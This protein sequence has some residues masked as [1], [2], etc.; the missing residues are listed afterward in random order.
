M[1]PGEVRDIWIPKGTKSDTEGTFQQR[2]AIPPFESIP[3]VI[4]QRAPH[5]A[6]KACQVRGKWCRLERGIHSG[7]CYWVGESTRQDPPG[8]STDAIGVSTRVVNVYFHAFVADTA[9][10]NPRLFVQ[11]AYEDPS[12]GK[13]K[14]LGK[15]VE[16]RRARHSI[17]HWLSTEPM[18]CGTHGLHVVYWL[19]YEE[20]QYMLYKAQK[21]EIVSGK[22]ILFVDQPRQQEVSHFFRIQLSFSLK[23]EESPRA[24]VAALLES[25][26]H[27]SSREPLPHLS[28]YT[29]L[30]FLERI[31]WE[32]RNAIINACSDAVA[33]VLRSEALT[34]DSMLS[35]LRLIGERRAHVQ[36]RPSWTEALLCTAPPA[37]PLSGPVQQ[38]VKGALSELAN[39][40]GH[41]AAY[42][43]TLL[44]NGDAGELTWIGCISW[45]LEPRQ[46]LFPRPTASRRQSTPTDIRHFQTGVRVS[47][48]NHRVDPISC[49]H[50]PLPCMQVVVLDDWYAHS[51]FADTW[52]EEAIFR[53]FRKLVD[54]A[55]ASPQPRPEEV[56]LTLLKKPWTLKARTGET[57]TYSILDMCESRTAPRLREGLC[58]SVKASL[59]RLIGGDTCPLERLVATF[60]SVPIATVQ[61]AVRRKVCKCSDWE[62]EPHLN[63]GFSP[64][65]MLFLI[66]RLQFRRDQLMSEELVRSFVGAPAPRV[67]LYI[68][69]RLLALLQVDPNLHKDRLD[70]G[71]VKTNV[72]RIWVDH[73][74]EAQSPADGVVHL[75]EH[76]AEHWAAWETDLDELHEPRQS[77]EVQATKLHKRQGMGG[78]ETLLQ[79][80]RRIGSRSLATSVAVKQWLVPSIEEFIGEWVDDQHQK[81]QR[82][83]RV[84]EILT[85]PKS[86]AFGVLVP[87]AL[88]EHLLGFMLSRIGQKLPKAKLLTYL[89]RED[90]CRLWQPLLQ[91]EGEQALI[92]AF[93][94]P[95]HETLGLVRQT[96]LNFGT[97]LDSASIEVALGLE[98]LKETKRTEHATICQYLRAF[99]LPVVRPAEILEAIDALLQTHDELAQFLQRC[100]AAHDHADY[101]RH[102]QEIKRLE[103]LRLDTTGYQSREAGQLMVMDD[104]AVQAYYQILAAIID[105]ARTSF[106]WRN[107][108]LFSH[109][110]DE[111]EQT[112]AADASEK[113]EQLTV[114]FLAADVYNAATES[115]LEKCKE[116]I[117][118]DDITIGRVSHILGN[119]LKRDHLEHELELLFPDHPEP[120]RVRALHDRLIWFTS[121][122]D[123]MRDACAM[124]GL[125]KN[126]C[127]EDNTELDPTTCSVIVSHAN[128]FKRAAQDEDTHL[129]DFA[130]ACNSF[131]ETLRPFDEMRELA[132]SLAE[133]RAGELIEFLHTVTDLRNLVDAQDSKDMA[134]T[135][136][137]L[138]KVREILR[139]ILPDEATHTGAA[140]TLPE[141]FE[142]LT[143]AA[144]AHSTSGAEAAVLLTECCSNLDGLRSAYAGLS[145]KSGQSKQKISSIV[146]DGQWIFEATGSHATLRDGTIMQRGLSQFVIVCSKNSLCARSCPPPA[147]AEGG[148]AGPFQAMLKAVGA[149]LTGL[150][151]GTILKD[152]FCSKAAR[153]DVSFD[154]RVELRR[155]DEGVEALAFELYDFLG[156]N[157]LDDLRSR[158]LLM[159]NSKQE[160]TDEDDIAHRE[161]LQTFLNLAEKADSL[162]E[163]VS[164]LIELGHFEA[165]RFGVDEPRR[166]PSGDGALKAERDRI[167]EMCTQWRNEL[168]AVRTEHYLTS[169]FCSSQLWQLWQLLRSGDESPSSLKDLLYY[170][171]A[172]PTGQ[173]T[174]VAEELEAHNTPDFRLLGRALDSLFET[175]MP[176]HRVPP[177]WREANAQVCIGTRPLSILA[178]VADHP[179]SLYVQP[180]SRVEPGEIVLSFVKPL[181]ETSNIVE[182]CLALYVADGYLPEHYQLLFCNDSTTKEEIDVFLHRAFHTHPLTEGRLF[183]VLRISRLQE[184]SYLHLIEALTLRFKG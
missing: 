85:N 174:A 159:I 181:P 149:D 147:Y 25:L 144:R 41:P 12:S 31:H 13:T 164:E 62:Y 57:K 59:W 38:S 107:S 140:R 48:V 20:V 23:G 169:F 29:L 30:T 158:A 138:M 137:A 69:P 178:L 119:H 72:T 77:I 130:T 92:G 71:S 150:E 133:P 75:F 86:G 73:M 61:E 37:E 152:L 113:G 33:K 44:R 60:E 141:A 180:K 40:G 177:E 99:D 32:S 35:L 136:N 134:G 128:A 39:Q 22:T 43:D 173:L 126:L 68:Y 116:L 139:P 88:S 5:F 56:L 154:Y 162:G 76:L 98:V 143:G 82:A 45:G 168:Q 122:A 129:R 96:L 117:D 175:S 155:T 9:L 87:H 95:T 94:L 112:R 121:R 172:Q 78:G 142:K 47:A 102:L 65:Q 24:R 7:H 74:L 97:A 80:A 165:Q 145:D 146:A 55:P 64:E 46:L 148:D 100:S 52:G 27:G 125:V 63:L 26:L 51:S 163:G 53:L 101:D 123:T 11:Q 135:I 167:F 108:Q 89:L 1:K 176:R 15:P 111:A 103:A 2:S 19:E 83:S 106:R 160:S 127:V 21:R 79:A 70:L 109:E 49:S 110:W 171:P 34:T 183:C 3:G 118:N 17:N 84:V 179:I 182:T 157:E 170:I 50:T 93:T 151:L 42:N 91:V 81:G 8:A 115:F 67:F 10:L 54:D 184:A 18:E 4:R 114:S 14:L 6:T 161:E 104:H 90:Q 58:N 166:V 156:S 105:V 66:D 131:Y 16:L 153:S 124:D 36:H 28:V 132:P 120:A